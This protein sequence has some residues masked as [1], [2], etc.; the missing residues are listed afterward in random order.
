MRF[1]HAFFIVSMGCL[2]LLA[3]LYPDDKP[4][5]LSVIHFLI[6]ALSIAIYVVAKE[7]DDLIE[8]QKSPNQGG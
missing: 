4:S 6:W 3:F 7:L 5:Y 1:R 2:F 8:K